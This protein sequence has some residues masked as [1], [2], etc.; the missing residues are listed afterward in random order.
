MKVEIEDNG[1]LRGQV[2]GQPQ[3]FVTRSGHGFIVQTTPTGTLVTRVEDVA[4]IMAE[5]WAA[6]SPPADLADE[7]PALSLVEKGT[8]T[9][10]GR[11]GK[12]YFGKGGDGKLSPQP[13]VVISGDPL[14]APLGKAMATQFAMSGVMMA[15]TLGRV[16]A[17]AKEMQRILETGA[18]LLF[19]GAE[20]KS[21]ETFPIDSARF[22]LP[23]PPETAEEVRAR[24]L[25]TKP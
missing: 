10:N 11:A 5:Q 22:E 7:L 19:A 2:A 14:L 21:V 18:P 17:F 13:V 9:I 8:V 1:D 12:A 4:A 16:P 3:Y 25:P 20:L 23:T 24:L 6:L 15:Q